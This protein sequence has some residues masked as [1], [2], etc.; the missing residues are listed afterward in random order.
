MKSRKGGKLPS[1]LILVELKLVEEGRRMV[2]LTVWKNTANIFT[3]PLR[4][5]FCFSALN[6]GGYRNI[7]VSG[8]MLCFTGIFLILPLILSL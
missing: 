5:T 2:F 6:C 4:H 3:V 8:V 7:S 1:C